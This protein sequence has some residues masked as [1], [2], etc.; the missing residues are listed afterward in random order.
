MI[1]GILSVG[2]GIILLIAGI[3]LSVTTAGLA[4]PFL[5]WIFWGI[6]LTGLILLVVGIV[7]IV[8]LHK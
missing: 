5:G 7:F 1:K 2:I 4:I 8:V 6:S 3:V